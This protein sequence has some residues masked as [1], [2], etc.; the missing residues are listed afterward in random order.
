[1]EP[2]KFVIMRNGGWL[3]GPLNSFFFNM[4]VISPK[5]L[6]YSTY[7][8]AAKIAEQIKGAQVAELTEGNLAN[9][10]YAESNPNAGSAIK[11]LSLFR[12][13]K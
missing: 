8:D 1:M 3:C 5:M 2:K 6:R 9:I 12:L 7:N 13:S 11:N 10:R 4:C